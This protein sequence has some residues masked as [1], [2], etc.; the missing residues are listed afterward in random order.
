MDNNRANLKP[1]KRSKL[2]LKLGKMYYTS[3]RYLMWY[4][5]RIKFAKYRSTKKLP[6]EYF[7][8]KTLLLR[9]L[10]DV[11]M[12]YQYN[13]IIN[14]KIAVNK[15]NG[16]ILHPGEMF[17]YWKLIGKPTKK[18][19]YVE[20][21]VLSYGKFGYGVGGGLCQLSNL[22]FWMTLHTPLTVVERYRHSFDVFP[23]SN[24]T[25]PFGSGATCVYPYR[26]L[27]IR[28]DT[29]TDF[30]LCLE[31]GKKYLKG[32]WYSLIK[33][34]CVYKVVEKNHKMQREYWGGFSRHNELYQQKYDFNGKLIDEQ[35]ITENH[36]LMMYV[37]FLEEHS[38]KS[39]KITNEEKNND[40][41]V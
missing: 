8:H 3:A 13:K 20:G 24:R 15:I 35:Y 26:D 28:N 27:M 4:F 22:I 9:K 1:I 25:Q 16:I 5:N 33:P 19:G 21:M 14:L 30:Q 23:D 34:E 31:V 11:D 36:A 38:N 17:S 40:I 39:D 41:M 29:D 18:K 10:K 6:Y 2:R 37:P 12:Q 7:S 32:K